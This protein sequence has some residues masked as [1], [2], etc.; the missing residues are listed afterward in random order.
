MLTWLYIRSAAVR[1]MFPV[2]PMLA[3]LL[4]IGFTT[5]ISKLDPLLEIYIYIELVVLL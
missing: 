4:S 5:V 2:L 3:A 1:E